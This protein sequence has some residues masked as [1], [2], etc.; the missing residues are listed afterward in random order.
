MRGERGVGVVPLELPPRPAHGISG[1][2]DVVEHHAVLV[3]R[4]GVTVLL[5]VASVRTVAEADPSP[6]QELDAPT[7]V[8]RPRRPLDGRLLQRPDRSAGSNRSKLAQG[9][10]NT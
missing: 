5:P 8:P 4:Y 7:L 3:E 2:H 6:G 10:M 1:D 9:P